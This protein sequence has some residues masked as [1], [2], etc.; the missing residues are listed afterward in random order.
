MKYGE[1]IGIGFIFP[2]VIADPNVLN[3]LDSPLIVDANA[4][5]ALYFFNVHVMAKHFQDKA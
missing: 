2:A 3:E 4:D 1:Y 5:G